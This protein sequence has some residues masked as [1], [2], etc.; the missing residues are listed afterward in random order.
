MDDNGRGNACAWM[1][2]IW[3]MI[4]A[5]E[6][7]EKGEA[8]TIGGEPFEDEIDVRERI[9]ESVLSV[10]VRSDW[11]SPGEQMKPEEYCILLTTGGPAARI[12]GR[13]S[14]YGEP[15]TAILEY[16]DWG[17]PWTRLAVCE[18]E[19]GILLTFAACFYFGE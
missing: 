1:D 16:Q 18:D 6:S 11:A 9:S 14:E 4:E 17:T 12:I 10:E 8:A 3:E 2:N 19:R 13:L 5:L 15:E 7:T